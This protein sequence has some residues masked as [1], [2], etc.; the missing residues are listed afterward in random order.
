MLILTKKYALTFREVFEK[1]TTFTY[2]WHDYETLKNTIEE[3]WYEGFIT[4]ET[5]SKVETLWNKVL[6]EFLD[7]YIFIG[8]KKIDDLTQSECIDLSQEFIKK[9]YTT[10]EATKDYYETLIGFYDTKK[11]NLLDKVQSTTD[12]KVKFNDVPQT[13]A[14]EGFTGDAY[15]TNYTHSEGT[16]GS[17]FA[18]LMTRLREIQDDFKNVWNDWIYEFRKLFLEDNWEV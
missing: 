16:N 6:D 13:T 7:H 9:F 2:N 8:D 11:A 4:F 18:T 5:S 12:N 10:Y 15:A 17:D 14:Q 1:A 3:L